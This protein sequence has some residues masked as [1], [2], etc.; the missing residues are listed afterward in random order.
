MERGS[1]MPMIAKDGQSYW[2]LEEARR[3]LCSSLWR[4]CSPE[5]SFIL[6]FWTPEP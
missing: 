5:D 1:Y 2:E 6:D 4:D 3:V